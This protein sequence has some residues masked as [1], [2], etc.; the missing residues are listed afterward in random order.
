MV[1]H[2]K[3]QSDEVCLCLVMLF[4]WDGFCCCKKQRICIVCTQWMYSFCVQGAS[5]SDVPD[6]E[7]FRAGPE[8]FRGWCHKTCEFACFSAQ[9][10]ATKTPRVAGSPLHWNHVLLAKTFGFV[11]LC[12]DE[13]RCRD[14]LNAIALPFAVGVTKSK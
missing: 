9:S 3:H 7:S 11:W 1:L 8:S 2:R 6:R 4:A 14:S 12:G 13:H 10:I 5:L